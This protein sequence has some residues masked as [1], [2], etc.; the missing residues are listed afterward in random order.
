[1]SE[2]LEHWMLGKI[3]VMGLLALD[4]AEITGYKPMS[5]DRIGVAKDITMGR[6]LVIRTVSYLLKQ[7][8]F[9][10]MP[11]NIGRRLGTD[12]C[13]TRCSDNCGTA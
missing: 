2:Q 5:C 7:A 3:T 13:G 9:P 6:G 10:T 11:G 4:G 1:M 12:I 8:L